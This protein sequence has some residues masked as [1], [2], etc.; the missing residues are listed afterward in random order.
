MSFS[1]ANVN[2]DMLP[3]LSKED[4]CNLFP[5]PEHFFRR[6]AIWKTTHGQIEVI[7]DFNIVNHAIIY[8]SKTFPVLVFLF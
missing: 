4:L 5:G 3:S 7:L 6:R 2:T 1:A 8:V